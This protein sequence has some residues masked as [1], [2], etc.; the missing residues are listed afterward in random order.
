MRAAISILAVGL[1]LSVASAALAAGNG[2]PQDTIT[3]TSSA[4][5]TLDEFSTAFGT[6]T[7]KAVLIGLTPANEYRR[8]DRGHRVRVNWNGPL[9]ELLNGVAPR[10]GLQWAEE[11]NAILLFDASEARPKAPAPAPAV[12]TV[13][14]AASTV[15]ARG[16]SSS[17][18]ATPATL[19]PVDQHTAASAGGQGLYLIH[20]TEPTSPN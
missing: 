11:G 1:S 5:M 2:S 18:T 8:H 13:E 19:P 16:Q 7:G 17:Q 9:A 14:V 3:L 20:I 15:A 6:A 12:A 4:P 10:F